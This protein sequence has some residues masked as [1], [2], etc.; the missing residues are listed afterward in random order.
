MSLRPQ[1]RFTAEDVIQRVE[2]F[3]QENHTPGET[4]MTRVKFNEHKA[5]IAWVTSTK[6]KSAAR[7]VLL[8]E[9]ERFVI[10]CKAT[11]DKRGHWRNLGKIT[12]QISALKTAED[13]ATQSRTPSKGTFVPVALAPTANDEDRQPSASG[14]APAAGA[15]ANAP[16]SLGA[17]SVAR[18]PS[19]EEYK[20]ALVIS[21]Q[22]SAAG[23]KPI[24]EVEAIIAAYD[25]FVAV[26]QTAAVRGDFVTASAGPVPTFADYSRAMSNKTAKAAVGEEPDP[27]DANVIYNYEMFVIAAQAAM[28]AKLD[29]KGEH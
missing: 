11:K 8:S 10:A 21:A 25:E 17:L 24:P 28:D 12:A 14:S 23:T 13:Q 1:L 5:L 19:F 20:R 4:Y 6:D 18:L 9:V 22:N 29:D 16:V 7:D 15:G 3:F 26:V 27:T 2:A